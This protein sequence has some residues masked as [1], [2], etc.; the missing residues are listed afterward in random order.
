MISWKNFTDIEF[1]GTEMPDGWPTGE[2]DDIDDESSLTDDRD[3]NLDDFS[4]DAHALFRQRT[5]SSAELN[6]LPGFTRWPWVY[7]R[8]TQHH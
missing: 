1:P 4:L 7:L 3:D 5:P 8:G 6:F 2:D